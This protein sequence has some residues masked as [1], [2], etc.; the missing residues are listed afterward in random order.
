M[1]LRK[2]SK[3]TQKAG[4]AEMTSILMAYLNAQFGT[5]IEKFIEREEEKAKET[6]AKER[7]NERRRKEQKDQKTDFKRLWTVKKLPDGTCKISAYKGALEELVF[8]E[9]IDGCPISEIGHRG[10]VC[11]NEEGFQALKRVVL[12]AS[13]RA[14]GRNVFSSSSLEEITIPEGVT[15]IEDGVFMGTAI[16]NIDIRDILKS[17]DITLLTKV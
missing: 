1:S 17:R 5:G 16:T 11:L 7:D 14:I 8:P 3:K 12:P 4:Y 9:E 6:A 15:S 13:L 10:N 2:T